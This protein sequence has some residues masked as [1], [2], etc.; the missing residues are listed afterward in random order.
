MTAP[1]VRLLFRKLRRFSMVIPNVMQKKTVCA[2]GGRTIAVDSV[3]DPSDCAAILYD[4][5]SNHASLLQREAW[6][7][8][9]R[10]VAG[11]A[12]LRYRGARSA[13]D[14]LPVRCASNGES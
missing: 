3:H 2:R 14:S 7:C 9:S 10:D 12:C 13:A 4:R 1:A 8:V 6:L 11:P 5:Y